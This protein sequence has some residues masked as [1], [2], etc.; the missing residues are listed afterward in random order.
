MT[1]SSMK[2]ATLTDRAI[3]QVGGDEATGFLQGL[4]CNNM[5]KLAKTPSFGDAAIFT[6]LLTPQG[7]IMFDFFIIKFGD[8]YL[9]DCPASVADDLLKRL[10]FY[11]LRAKVD[12][13]KRDDLRVVVGWSD[14]ALP[15]LDN[16]S[17]S[18]FVQEQVTCF[19]DPHL[20]DLDYRFILPS[21]QAMQEHFTGQQADYEAYRIAQAVPE[22]G[23]DYAWSDIFPHDAGFDLLNGVDFKKGCYVGQEV[24]SKMHHKA[25]LRKRFAL[26]E[27]QEDLPVQGAEIKGG[28]SLI[29]VL[30]SVAGK[31]GLSLIRL[32]RAQKAIEKG[33][34]FEVEGVKVKLVKPQ[35]A[36]YEVASVSS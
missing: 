11:R 36:N 20:P 34:S 6:G 29:G 23:K 32:D 13:K 35:W 10:M 5:E 8:G 14:D 7:K 3:L 18:S 28:A 30:A 15:I 22:G 1:L 21:D 33:D 12:L 2:L 26:V 4:V 24:V 16:A 9:I 19:D 25:T 31:Q 27:A 17:V